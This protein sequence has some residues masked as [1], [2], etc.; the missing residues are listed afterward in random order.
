MR[1]LLAQVINCYYVSRHIVVM[2]L[3]ACD[4]ISINNFKFKFQCIPVNVVRR[5][6]WPVG[7]A[8]CNRDR[9][10]NHPDRIAPI[11][12]FSHAWLHRL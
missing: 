2:C 4:T 5:F 3:Y 11:R 6:F 1:V 9:S 7:P 8:N 12:L 10:R